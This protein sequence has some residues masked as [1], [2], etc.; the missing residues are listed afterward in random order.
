MVSK[1]P[2]NLM[3]GT[4]G[5]I[6]RMTDWL[7][8]NAWWIGLAAALLF[9]VYLLYRVLQQTA[10]V[11][12][13]QRD[14]LERL[15]AS[16]LEAA[17]ATR[18]PAKTIWL[19]GSPRHPPVHLGRYAGHHHS[20]DAL[21]IAYRPGLF[22][23]RRL[24]ALNPVDLATSLDVPELQLRGIGVHMAR[25]L[26]YLVPDIHDA[27]VRAAWTTSARDGSGS[28]EGMAEAVKAY[29]ARATDNAGAFADA[30]TA[31]E[32]RAF[33][34]QEVTRSKREYTETETIAAPPPASPTAEGAPKA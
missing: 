16:L 14:A 22:R 4:T 15:R 19:T 26:G 32:D 9:V 18:G 3:D 31:I 7:G 11:K 13:L 2:P 28:P 33:L 1:E 17:S 5:T 23:K 8:E 25:D 20:V 21:W 12:R 27:D 24:V 10:R 29:Y 6:D 34:R 30:L